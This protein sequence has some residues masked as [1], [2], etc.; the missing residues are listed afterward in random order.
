M[1][2]IL[3]VFLVDFSQR[4][5]LWHR[6]PYHTRVHCFIFGRLV[7]PSIAAWHS[8]FLLSSSKQ[9]L[10][11]RPTDGED[12]RVKKHSLAPCNVLPNTLFC[13]LRKSHSHSSDEMSLFEIGCNRTLTIQESSAGEST[14][15][16]AHTFR[17]HQT[18]T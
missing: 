1:N 6:R 4:R 7:Q 10:S 15:F 9:K 2:I 8:T 16:T 3:A 11:R 17:H 13:S 18:C 12:R 5:V 14:C